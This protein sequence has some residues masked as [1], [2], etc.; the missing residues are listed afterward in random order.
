MNQQIA[1]II[2]GGLIAAAI[3]LT[4]YWE[5]VQGGLLD[6]WTGG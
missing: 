5:A 6:R 4:N 1:T 3:A 2:A